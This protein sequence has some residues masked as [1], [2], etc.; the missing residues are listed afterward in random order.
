MVAG[1]REVRLP[2]WLLKRRVPRKALA[3]AVRAVLPSL[4]R[5]ERTTR[6]RG[7]WVTH[8]ITQRLLGVFIFVLALL[9][10]LPVPGTNVPPALAIFITALG[11][12]ERDGWA[13]ALG[14]L[15]GLASIALIG[16]IALGM[17]K[18]V[19]KYIVPALPV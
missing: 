12:V 13:I 11:M 15:L 8:P 4:E 2:K 16:G 1:C 19:K 17:L 5:A 3:A 10:A 9:I 18:L 6:A 7:R 14:V